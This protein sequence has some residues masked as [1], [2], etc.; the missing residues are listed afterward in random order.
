MRPLAALATRAPATLSTTLRSSEKKAKKREITIG[1]GN[2]P[3]RRIIS[4][5]NAMVE[6]WWVDVEQRVGEMKGRRWLSG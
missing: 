4:R 5:L 3:A 1:N 6:G 2:S